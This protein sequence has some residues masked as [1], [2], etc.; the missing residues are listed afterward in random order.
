MGGW[1][2]WLV[3]GI[4]IAV[5]LFAYVATRSRPPVPPPAPGESPVAYY[6]QHVKPILQAR[7]YECHGAI[8]SEG[9]LRLDT[10]QS[11]LQGG[12]RGPAVVP[13]HPETSLLIASVR[14]LDS[15]SPMPLDAE[16][17]I[18]AQTDTLAHWVR[19]GAVGPGDERP[20]NPAA[21]HWAFRP[22]VE[23][24]VP[25]LAGRRKFPNPI[26]AF[27]AEQ[28]QEHG[29]SPQGR[30]SK[31]TLLR[32]AS[33]DLVGLPPTPA[34]MQAFLA[35][36]S[37]DAYEHAVD[38]LLESPQ[39]GVRWARHWLDIWRYK[40]HDGR[41]SQNGTWSSN[42][43]LWVWRDWTIRSL[44]R[45]KRYDRILLEMLAGD[46]LDP[47]NA[48]AL[49]ATGFIVRNWDKH[50][51]HGW[52]DSLVEHTSRAFLGLKLHCARCHD[53]KYD[54]ISQL[55]YYQVRACFEPHDI[56]TENLKFGKSK[57]KIR[58]TFAVDAH[59]NAQTQVFHRGEPDAPIEDLIVVPNVPEMIRGGGL[60]IRPVTNH[61]GTESTGRRLALARW[62]VNPNHPLTARVAVNHI[63]MRHFGSPLVETVDDFGLNGSVPSHPQLLDWL[64]VN[65]R[66][67]GWSQK[68][69]HRQ[70]MTSETYRLE[71]R[72]QPASVANADVD[73][74]NRFLWRMNA[75]RMEGEIVRDSMLAL[76]RNLDTSLG[77]PPLPHDA[78][79]TTNRRSIYYRYS[80]E[81]KPRLL[82]VFDGAN[83]NE[84]YRRTVSTTPQQ[85]LSICNGD[86]AWE[87][88][89][90][91]AAGLAGSSS[92]RDFVEAA[93]ATVL[94]RRP[95]TMEVQACLHFLQ[96]QRSLFAQGEV[97]LAS[98]TDAPREPWAHDDPTAAA[99]TWLVH[100]LL[101][102]N[103]FITI[104]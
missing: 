93:F 12:D 28:Y 37:P 56:Q 6:L 101:N 15:V 94:G 36:S 1:R 24:A 2:R 51:R 22:A 74:D 31:E 47:H 32:R 64:A 69:L 75:R 3:I 99:Q 35:D 50:D 78:A 14:H 38:R 72:L 49:A 30:A 66:K 98:A 8:R 95:S 102:H 23:P 57:K 39:Y 34:E 91:I 4:V 70:I 7:C 55:A 52:V 21:H 97:R 25:S 81:D 68:W 45:D 96:E 33:L 5:G 71:S 85:S 17:L 42:E 76:A 19:E 43:H 48:D 63:W 86:F 80:Q 65:F 73:P 54:P 20:D 44:N 53:H 77:G 89:G 104:R 40:E 103:D 41:K 27:I 13:G 83:V 29:L 82:S 92:D 9:G 67:N 11:I 60:D 79:D 26:D 61:A 18:A 46:E 100:A 84:C 10:V 90:R 62:L 88:A 58:T 87:Q 16:P 59:P